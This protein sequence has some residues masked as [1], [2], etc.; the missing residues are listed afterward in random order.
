LIG[1]I[2]AA[3]NY[4]VSITD[5]KLKATTREK[6]LGLIFAVVNGVYL[7]IT[8]VGINVVVQ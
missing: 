4:G 6:A 3:V 2:I 1:M 5:P 7:F 8:A